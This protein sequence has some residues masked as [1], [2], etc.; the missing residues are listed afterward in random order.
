MGERVSIIRTQFIYLFISNIWY[1]FFF[2]FFVVAVGGG[3]VVVALF[4]FNLG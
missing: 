4:C 1:F 2:F 3:V